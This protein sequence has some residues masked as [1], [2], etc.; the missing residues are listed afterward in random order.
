MNL[1]IIA[2]ISVAFI[3]CC[4]LL[5]QISRDLKNPAPPYEPKILNKATMNLIPKITPALLSASL[6]I[7]GKRTFMNRLKL[8]QEAPSYLISFSGDAFYFNFDEGEYQFNE[9]LI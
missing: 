6:S 7:K 2:L 4:F 8:R 3:K 5:F 9:D 1:I